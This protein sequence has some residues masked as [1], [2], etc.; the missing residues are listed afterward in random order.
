ME[1]IGDNNWVV[2]P[3]DEGKV[4]EPIFLAKGSA[5]VTNYDVVKIMKALKTEVINKASEKA[6]Y[7]ELAKDENISKLTA[8]GAYKLK[9]KIVEKGIKVSKEIQEKIDKAAKLKIP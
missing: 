9:E 4:G 7:T 6:M 2:I 8:D 5:L 1:I 3:D